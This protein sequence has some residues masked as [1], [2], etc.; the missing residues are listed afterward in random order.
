M[1]G[2]IGYNQFEY[3]TKYTIPLIRNILPNEF[4]GSV[5]FAR[6][7]FPSEGVLIGAGYLVQKKT[8]L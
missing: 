6:S 4:V 8:F 5:D 2:G 7:K 1:T 3:L